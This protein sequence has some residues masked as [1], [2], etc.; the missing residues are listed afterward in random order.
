MTISAGVA[1]VGVDEDVTAAI[2]RA[3]AFLY[4]AKGSGRNCVRHA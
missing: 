2:A 4:A 3:D 1:E